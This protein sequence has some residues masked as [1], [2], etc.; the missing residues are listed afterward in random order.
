M[1]WGHPPG[2]SRKEGA[3]GGCTSDLQQCFSSRAGASV[4]APSPLLPPRGRT[5]EDVK[6]FLKNK[7]RKTKQNLN[8][9]KSKTVF[10][11]FVFP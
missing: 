8:G 9:K 10:L 3:T 7:K 4:T 11:L 2:G 6:Y 5:C 1:A